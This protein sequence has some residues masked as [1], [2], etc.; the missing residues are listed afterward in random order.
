MMPRAQPP[1][2]VRGVG[3]FSL[4]AIA[5]NGMVGA[6]IFALPA[7]VAQ[8]LGAAAPLAYITAG[9]AILLIALCFAEAGSLFEGSGGPYLYAR[10]A[11]GPLIGF[12]AGWMYVLNRLTTVAAISNTFAAYLA[13]FWPR[14][15]VRWT[16]TVM[17]AILAAINC[18]GIKPGLRV[19]N[20]LTVGKLLPL[21]AFCA[22]GLF[23]IDGNRMSF[24]TLPPLGSLQ[25]AS[26]VL[27]FALGGFESASIPS[28]EV[29]RPRRTLPLALLVSVSAVVVLYL[30]IQIVATGTLPTLATTT[31]P[32]A[33]SAQMF[34]GAGGGLLLTIGAMLSTTGTNSASILTGPRMLYALAQGGHLPAALARIHRVYRTPVVAT[35]A[36]AG[37]AWALAISGTFT[38]LVGLA[39]LSRLLFYT[40]TCLAIPVLRRKMAAV[41]GRF[42]LPGGAAI[43]LAGVVVCLWLMSGSA[44]RA[45]LLMAVALAVGAALHWVCGRGGKSHP[46]PL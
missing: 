28:E 22:V 9:V 29:I 42:T 37:V 10:E 36:F 32:L 23:F 3:W 13:Y 20:L 2:L 44:L 43:P 38:Q 11:F 35:L 24:T 26:L 18:R 46:R 45:V 21:L 15:D 40:T 30:L 41:E 8:L 16:V 39:V 17:I 7:N 12:E 34:L 33:S 1:A 19:I 31:T 25:Q 14:V 4:T 6:G 5:I 27:I